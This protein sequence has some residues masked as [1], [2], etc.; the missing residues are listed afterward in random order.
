MRH[1][2]YYSINHIHNMTYFPLRSSTTVI[3]APRL[4]T[5]NFTLFHSP[6]AFPVA[7]DIVPYLLLNA[8]HTH[9]R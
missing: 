5:N 3:N 7:L 8:T 2:Q 9:T 1:I 6:K 4:K